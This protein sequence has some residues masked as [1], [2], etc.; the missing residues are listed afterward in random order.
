MQKSARLMGA[1]LPGS[2]RVCDWQE[3]NNKFEAFR[4]FQYADRE[5]KLAAGSVP[6]DEAV[7]CALTQDAFRAIWLIEGIGY[8]EGSAS[9]LSVEGL[10]TQG[11]ASRLP[12]R[13]MIPLHAG[14]GTAFGEKLLG[15]L[16]RDASKREIRRAVERFVDLCSANCRTGWDD[17]SIEPLGLVVRCLYPHLLAHVSSAMNDLSPALRGLFWHGVGRSLYFVPTHF[18]PIPGAHERMVKGAA[19]ETSR[20]DDRRQVLAGLVW[21]VALVNLPQP[22]VIRSLASASAGMRIQSEFSNGVI[23]ALLAWRHMAPADRRYAGAYT[24]PLPN[25]HQDALLW[26]AWIETPSR[27]ALETFYPGLDDQNRIPALYTYRSLEEFRNLTA[28]AGEE[29]I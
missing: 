21:A 7:Q 9:S 22:K 1:L 11:A 14:M 19:A 20:P 27:E 12:D 4:L 10:L 13:A 26:K 5:L 18:M 2:N 3:F 16:G 29:R 23:S 25:H 15:G 28:L 8:I 17:A 24:R 6:I